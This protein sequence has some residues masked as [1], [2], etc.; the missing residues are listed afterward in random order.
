VAVAPETYVNCVSTRK[1]DR[2]VER[3]GI[4]GMTKDRVLPLCRALDEQ[5]EAFRH[6]AA[7]HLCAQDHNAAARTRGHDRPARFVLSAALGAES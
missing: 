7:P 4:D 5:V 2:L 3:L 6:P 1:V